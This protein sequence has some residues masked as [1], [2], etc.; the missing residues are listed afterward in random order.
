MTALYFLLNLTI[1]IIR[2]MLWPCGRPLHATQI[3]VSRIG[4]VGD[5]A[6]S[7][8]AIY[9]IRENYPGARLVLLTSPGTRGAPGAQELLKDAGW[10]DEIV[11][12][13]QDE[14]GGWRG[15]LKLLRDLRCYEFDVWIELPPNLVRFRTAARNM[16]AARIAGARW[17]YGWQISTVRVRLQRQAKLF[18]FPVEVDRLITIVERAGMTVPKVQ[19]PLP[20]T[21]EIKE[22]IDLL[23]R[24]NGAT[25]GP[26]VAIAPAAKRPTNVWPENRFI[27]V[28]RHL[29][30]K[31]LQIVVMGGLGDR[32][33]CDRIADGIGTMALSVAGR[34]SLVESCELLKRCCLLIC[35]DSGVQHLAAAAGTPSVSIFSSR[36]VE[37]KWH[38]YGS[39]N[40][41]L[42]NWVECDTCLLDI[43]P[44]NNRC[45]NSIPVS[46]VV[47]A[48]EGM[49]S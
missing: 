44:Y 24:A 41:V 42:R 12:Y 46:E 48:A 36:D 2:R 15:R 9:A 28:G 27:E 5:I 16:I 1:A 32:R 40:R 13:Y 39:R 47:A 29:A 19:F 7:I 11:T 38:P 14:I 22:T 23:L 25:V 37:G 10:L 26:I 3:C 21:R 33:L 34:T 6:C 8:P 43:C 30:R 18:S 4:N 17:A 31:G 35:N 45:I 20:I 49:M